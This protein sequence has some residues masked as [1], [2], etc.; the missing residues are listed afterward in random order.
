MDPARADDPVETDDA[1][2]V[3]NERY[4]NPDQFG[5]TSDPPVSPEDVVRYLVQN[6]PLTH[7]ADISRFIDGYISELRQ[8]SFAMVSPHSSQVCHRS[9]AVQQESLN[10]VV[11]TEKEITSFIDGRQSLLNL[12]TRP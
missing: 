6:E 5:S 10:A 7:V 2:V 9:Y 11:D 4:L 8:D 1:Y 3:C 12:P